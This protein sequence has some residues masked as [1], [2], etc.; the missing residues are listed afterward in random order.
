MPASIRHCSC[1]STEARPR[2]RRELQFTDLPAGP[3]TC[4][5]KR[6]TQAIAGRCSGTLLAGSSFERHIGSLRRTI[7]VPAKQKRS[8]GISMPRPP[9]EPF[10]LRDVPSRSR[11]RAS[12][13]LLTTPKSGIT[14]KTGLYHPATPLPTN[15]EDQDATRSSYNENLLLETAL[16]TY[17]CFSATVSHPSFMTRSGSCQSWRQ[18]RHCFA[19]GVRRGFPQ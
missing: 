16:P 1:L 19:T 13:S 11:Y 3:C 17:I 14:R 12:I 18:W 7:R 15:V 8:A 6:L 4:I 5:R 2:S 9:G 10:I